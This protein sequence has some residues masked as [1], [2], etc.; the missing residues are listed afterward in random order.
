MSQTTTGTRLSPAASPTGSSGQ[1]HSFGPV[2]V[3]LPSAC[4]SVRVTLT[5]INNRGIATVVLR[6]PRTTCGSKFAVV[7][8]HSEGCTVAGAANDSS[9]PHYYATN[10]RKKKKPCVFSDQ[11][12]LLCGLIVK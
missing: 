10:K 4:R 6:S 5:E 3:H 1:D 7:H 12:Y 11:P 9:Q 8:C 2:M